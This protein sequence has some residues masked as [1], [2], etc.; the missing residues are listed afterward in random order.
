M[1]LPLGEVLGPAVR[2]RIQHEGGLSRREGRPAQDA[3][4]DGDQELCFCGMNRGVKNQFFVVRS[5]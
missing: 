1:P 4:K 5:Q 3:K 2:G